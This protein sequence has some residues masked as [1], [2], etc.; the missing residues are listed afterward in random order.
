ML[1]QKGSHDVP[2]VWVKTAGREG[3]GECANT[4]VN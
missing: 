1:F 4:T 3:D 2:I